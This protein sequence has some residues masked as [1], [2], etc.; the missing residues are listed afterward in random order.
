MVA[1]RP[2]WRNFGGSNL[3]ERHVHMGIVFFG[4]GTREGMSSKYNPRIIGKHRECWTQYVIF[5]GINRGRRDGPLRL[6][7]AHRGWGLEL[8]RK[9]KCYHGSTSRT[10]DTVGVSSF[11]SRAEGPEYWHSRSFDNENATPT[12][13]TPFF[14]HMNMTTYNA[15]GQRKMAIDNP[16]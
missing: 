14:A 10:V 3:G 16:I 11:Q 9:Q 13:A 4:R 7:T 1:P 12:R 2:G 8:K 15:H 5:H 6:R